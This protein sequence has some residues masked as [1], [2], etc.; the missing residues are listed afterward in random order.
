MHAKFWYKILKETA[1][2]EYQSIDRRMSLNELQT[3]L[4]ENYG[5]GLFGS[6]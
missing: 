6:V 2:L 1:H 3:N 5:P 4:L